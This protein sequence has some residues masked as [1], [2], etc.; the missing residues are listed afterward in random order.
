MDGCGVG[1]DD[2]DD[3]DEEGEKEEQEEEDDKVEKEVNDMLLHESSTFCCRPLHCLCCFGEAKKARVFKVR[4]KQCGHD[5]HRPEYREYFLLIAFS[6][7]QPLKCS[8]GYSISHFF[9][10]LVVHHR[11]RKKWNH[12]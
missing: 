8:M 6:S 11:E 1:G 7:C 5:T 4:V 9:L 2:D 12:L 3:R 10:D